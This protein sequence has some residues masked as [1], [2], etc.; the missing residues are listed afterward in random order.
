PYSKKDLRVERG[1]T[2]RAD[3]RLEWSANLGTIGDDT[4]LTIRNRYAGIKGRTPRTRDGKPDLSG[5]WNGSEDPN[6]EEVPLLPWA[7]AIQKQRVET[8]FKDAPSGF[9]LPGEVLPS[10]PFVYKFIQTPSLF[11]QLSED[12]PD[13]RQ[14]FLDKRDHPKNL[15][16]SWKG[17][18]TGKWDGE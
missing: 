2:L 16:P 13:V 8:D 17:H 15:N 6:K 1:Q 10:S 9:C 11:L 4:F 7:A 3:V 18:S 14:V 12:I 5:I